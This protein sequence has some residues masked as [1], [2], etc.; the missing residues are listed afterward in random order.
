MNLKKAFGRLKNAA[1]AAIARGPDGFPVN[2]GSPHASC[3]KLINEF[4]AEVP[5]FT[6]DYQIKPADYASGRRMLEAPEAERIALIE[7]MLHRMAWV[8]RK[9]WY[10]FSTSFGI[11]RKLAHQIWRRELP[12]TPD[13]AAAVVSI[14]SAQMA[15]THWFDDELG[16]ILK[17]CERLKSQGAL[18]PA[19]REA[20]RHL[21][22]SMC[23]GSPWESAAR[24]RARDTIGRLIARQPPPP[25]DAGEAWSN[26]AL[27][28]LKALPPAQQETW[29]ALL[30]HCAGA[31]P[32][33]P[34]RKWSRA[35][36]EMVEAVGRDEF[37]MRVVRWF[38][39]VAQPRPVH[40]AAP[41]RWQPDPDYLITDRN[42]G[43]L[44]GLAWCCADWPDPEISSALGSLAEASFKKIPWLGAR[45]PKVGNACLHSLSATSSDHAAAQLSRLDSMVKQPTVKKRIGKSLDAAA[46]L[47]GQTRGDLEEKSVPTFGFG[48]DG[49]LERVLGNHR[50]EL[51]VAD[52]RDAQVS[53]FEAGGKSLKSVPAE[54]KREHTEGLKQLQKLARE[55]EKMLR[56]QRIRLER[57]LMTE[58]EWDFESWRQRYLD[59]PLLAPITRRLLWHFKHGDR[60]ALGIWFDGRLVDVELR[61]LE[62]LAPE[63][64]VRLWHPI[65]FPVETVSGWRRWLETNQVC[66]PFK[67]AH[68]EI[69][70]LTDAELQTDTY[71]NRFAAHIIGQHQFAALAAQRS[72]KYALM[73]N[74]DFQCTPTLEL[75]AWGMA[76]EFWVETT[77]EMADSG[78]AR[79]LSTDQVRFI[80]DGQPLSLTD[81]PAPVFSEVMRDVDLFVGVCSIGNDP[82]WQDRG[83]VP[84]AG[85]YWQKVSFGELSATAKTRRDVLGR[86][87]PKLSIAGKCVLQDRFLA[88]KG[89]LRSYKIHLGSGNILMEPNDQYL[90]IVPARGSAA[91]K[92]GQIFLPFEGDTTLAI[93]LSKAFLLADDAN[94]KD[95]GILGQIR[96]R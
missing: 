59:Q 46:A 61:P 26:A 62:W 12:Y 64:R 16:P 13:Q 28:D 19:L 74:F 77:G 91:A 2:P 90:C 82:G 73:G 42:A 30:H 63:T 87:L 6:R 32:S 17:I 25:L 4:L 92:S 7:A 41:S 86:L 57:L 27:E 35:A 83:E 58:R 54:V 39:L 24:K 78:I 89:T 29:G 36:K 94:I 20:L 67:Q 14:I 11:L 43:V 96:F 37:K 9:H 52:G 38:D 60:S 22:G 65:G 66:Q 50:A 69:Y 68:R 44:K 56:A 8:H 1:A 72:W 18:S 21:R 49:K 3:H 88:V 47:T 55:I 93:I 48:L 76:A 23:A 33:K 34:T 15:G 81:V 84:G 80:R 31:T 53:W 51:S 71:S 45:C 79:Y 95:Q 70:A 10:S 5:D 85:A 40:R 75:P